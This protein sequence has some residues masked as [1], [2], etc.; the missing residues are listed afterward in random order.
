[1]NE[2]ARSIGK[3]YLSFKL[4]NTETGEDFRRQEKISG[5]RRRE[6]LLTYDKTTQRNFFGIQHSKQK[7]RTICSTYVKL[8]ANKGLKKEKGKL[9]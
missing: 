5:D 6:I 4:G 2:L 9:G 3:K 1:M 8:E 7:N